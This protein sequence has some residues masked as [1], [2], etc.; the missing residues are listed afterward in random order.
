MD[1]PCD[2]FK[3]LNKMIK[4]GFVMKKVKEI[5]KINMNA[6]IAFLRT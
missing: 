3:S 1:T 2:N 6:N 4:N 5:K